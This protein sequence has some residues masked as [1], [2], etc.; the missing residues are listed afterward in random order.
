MTV[1][2]PAETTAGEATGG[3]TTAGDSGSSGELESS[4][5]EAADPRI[6][7]HE[8]VPNVLQY[9]GPIAVTVKAE[10]ADGVR[11]QVDGGEPVEL[12]P[13]PGN[14]FHG[15]IRFYSA[16][17]NGSDHAASVVA[18]RQA[19]ESAPVTIPL[20]VA[21]PKAGTELY[22]E[23][24][25]SL[26]QGSVAGLT[27]TPDE[28]LLEFGTYHLQGQ[29]RCYLRRRTLDGVWGPDD[30]MELLPGET[31]SASRIAVDPQGVVYV[32]AQ[33]MLAGQLRWWLGRM[34][35]WGAEV[36]DVGLGSAG[37]AAYGLAV[38]AGRVAV[39]GT[40][41]K[42]TDVDATAWI[43]RPG[44]TV[45]VLSFD[46]KGEGADILPFREMVRDCAFVGESLI[47]VGD[48]L[49]FHNAIKINRKRHLLLEFDTIAEQHVEHVADAGPGTQSRGQA[50]A[51]GP[52][53][54]IVTAGYFCDD[55]C[56]PRAEVRLFAGG[57][58]QIWRE[59]LDQALQPPRVIA[60]HPADYI[61][62]SSSRDE[63]LGTT[64]FFVQGWV[65]LHS[66]PL[67]SYANMDGPALHE[68]S[69][70]A[71]GPHGQ[72]YIGGVAAGGYPALAIVAP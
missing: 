48:T 50:L 11:M 24:D 62:L 65:P 54:K 20:T 42:L 52:G 10:H 46:Y 67:W 59:T 14:E 44:E 38:D 63:G 56:A 1:S 49:G 70:Q 39:C 25:E 72:V 36:S 27:V 40:H 41:D 37:D 3:A 5:G 28:R 33:R 66:V 29:P 51:V 64:S 30:V 34:S 60:W 43:F 71:I 68:A 2:G 47:A 69:A 9:P 22:W 8:L 55:V 61:I 26:G 23:R 21:L 31:C 15:E 58:I 13:G 53:S 19:L 7:D 6:I 12:T 45:Q 18:F 16:L 35:A 4:T 32:L 57:G 17:A